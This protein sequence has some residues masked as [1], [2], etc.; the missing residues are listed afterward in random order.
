MDQEQWAVCLF[1]CGTVEQ[2]STQH[3][4]QYT[5][6]STK[7]HSARRT[8]VAPPGRAGGMDQEQWA[9]DRVRHWERDVLAEYGDEGLPLM[10]V[11]KHACYYWY[12]G[13]LSQMPTELGRYR[14]T[15]HVAGR[16]RILRR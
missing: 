1:V 16:Q 6:Q 14:C 10:M 12:L 9:K 3:R 2:Q 7:Q 13:T 15:V 4:H 8:R 5:A 11:D